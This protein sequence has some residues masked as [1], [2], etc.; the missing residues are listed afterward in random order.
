MKL[1]KELSQDEKAGAESTLCQS[2]ASL[3][4]FEKCDTVLLFSPIKNE[5]DLLSIAKLAFK[6]G[7]R[8]AFPISL[9]ETCT[10]DFRFIQALDELT[11]GTYGINEPTESAP[12]ASF[13][14]NTICIVPAL[15]FDKKGYRLG[16]GKGYYDR[17][18]KDFEGTSIGATLEKFVCDKLPT[19][20]TDV[21]IDI[22]ITERGVIHLK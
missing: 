6:V 21:A 20:D 11:A 14:K 10:L 22:I 17:F 13:T 4:V 8:V 9:S 19:N 16:Y 12:K 7:K 18:L 1:R 2:I 3:S 15:A 5:P